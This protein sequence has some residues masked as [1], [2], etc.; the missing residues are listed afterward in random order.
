MSKVVD[1]KMIRKNILF[2]LVIIAVVLLPTVINEA[3]GGV[4]EG[5]KPQVQEKRK[6]LAV[7]FLNRA[8]HGYGRTHCSHDKEP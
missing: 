2:G 8:S 6:F 4:D 3:A 7:I 5:E 1:I